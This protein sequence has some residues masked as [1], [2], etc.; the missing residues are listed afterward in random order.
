MT[1]LMIE[2]ALRGL[3]FAAAVGTG[4]AALRVSNV[5]VRKAAWTLVLIA[6]MAMPFLMRVPLLSKIPRGWSW[7]VPIRMQAT[8]VVKAAAPAP[9]VSPTEEVVPPVANMAVA[10]APKHARQAI[11]IEPLDVAPAPVAT[12]SPALGGETPTPISAVTPKKF[13]WPSWERMAI[14]AYWLVGG[15]LLLRLLIGFAA[16]V[17]LWMTAKEVSPLIAPEPGVRTSPR[18]A[19]PVT[20]GSGI[21]LPADYEQWERRRL[22]MVL[23]HERSH[24]RQ[25]DFYVQLAAGIYTAVFWFSPLGWCLRRHLAAL[26]E[27][28]SDRAGVEAANSSSDYAQVVLEFAA[29]PHRGLPGV[30]MARSCNLS[31][32]I[33]SLLNERLFHS[34]FA[35][36]R[37]RA[38]ASL[39]LIP[40]ALFAATALVRVPSAMAQSNPPQ[41]NP[42][43]PANAPNPQAAPANP[44][45][46]QSGPAQAP[47]AAAAPTTGQAFPDQGPNASKVLGPAPA[48]QPAPQAPPMPPPP[49]GQGVTQVPPGAAQTPPLPPLPPAPDVDVDSGGGMGIGEGQSG[50]TTTITNGSATHYHYHIAS[51]GDSYAVVSGSGANV[52]FSGDWS[53]AQKAQIDAARRMAHGPFLWFTHDG[54]SYVVTDPAIVARLDAMYEPMKELG[55]QQR[56]LGR[57]QRNLGEQQRELSKEET[58]ALNLSVQTQVNA[59][60]QKALADLEKE[61]S[62]WNA[63]TMAAMQAELKAAQA[64]LSP[65]KMAEIQKEVQAA[66]AELTPEKMAAVQAEMKAVQA[67]LSPEEVAEMQKQIKAAA[68]KWSAQNLAQMQA[69]LAE[70]QARLGEMQT[71]LSDRQA[72]VASRMGALGAEQGRL[73]EEEGRLGAA[74]ARMAA[75]IQA[76]VQ[77]IIQES[78]RNGKAQPVQ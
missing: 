25:L 19:S 22:R 49:Q 21:V 53:P 63:Q 58:D 18:I 28:I 5:P 1:G 12:A 37:R 7:V 70:V 64:E 43:N 57:T 46:S 39:L 32:R 26:G 54:K 24:V 66:G 33:E 38:V 30:A 50:S 74:Q 3:V 45:P 76:E 75:R 77:R 42:P 23:A 9:V 61:Q 13:A 36:G 2:A 29:L 15:A 59:E 69:R 73:G 34:A 60:M 40:V 16:A 71:R 27:T 65:E 11:A 31:R 20:I 8:P 62:Q 14:W 67:R 47:P 55:V 6:S 78:I 48:D 52:D 51:N 35:E 4:L 44:G 68:E 56:L 10:D 72:I 17:R 41:S